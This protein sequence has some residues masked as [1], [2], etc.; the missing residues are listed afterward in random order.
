MADERRDFRVVIGLVLRY[1]VVASFLVVALGSAL[2]F[3]EGQ[4]GYAQ[5]G[6]AEQLFDARN[7]FL[8]G[9]SPLVAGISSGKPYAIIDLGLIVLLA[10]PVARVAISTLLFLEERRY[11]FVWITLTVLAVLLGSMFIVAPLISG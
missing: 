8:I 10:T 1:G 9:L 4:T 2:L 7:R 6:T 3:I 5:L 11:A